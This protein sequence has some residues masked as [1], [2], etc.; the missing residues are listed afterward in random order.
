LEYASAANTAGLIS[1]KLRRA[2]NSIATT[3]AIGT[4]VL[5]FEKEAHQ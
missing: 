3:R 1:E 4:I 5:R 2:A